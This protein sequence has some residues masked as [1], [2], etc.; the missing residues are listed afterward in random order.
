MQ[1]SEVYS[2]L[3]YEVA[4]LIFM[5]KDGTI[6]LMLGTRNINIARL[7]HGFMGDK[8]GSRDRSANIN[9]GNIAVI[10]MVIGDVR[11][12]NINRLVRVEYH[13]IPSSIGE[14]DKIVEN[15][16][17]FKKEYEMTQPMEIN[18]DMLN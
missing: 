9:T 11:L 17:K 6:R 8:L 1:Y 10:D 5:K 13:G 14:L 4:T 18:I 15:Y 2:K 16:M 12:F 3:S 7:M